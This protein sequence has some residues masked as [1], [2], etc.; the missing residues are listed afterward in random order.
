M[1]EKKTKSAEK[2]AAKNKDKNAAKNKAA[3]NTKKKSLRKDKYAKYV[4]PK[5]TLIEHRKRMGWSDEEIAKA[6]GIAYSTFKVYKN[7]YGELSA[8][9]RVGAQEADAVVESAFFSRCVGSKVLLKKPFKVVRTKEEIDG[10]M[11]DV[12]K[13]IYADEEVYFPPDV[14]A[15]K[16]YLEHRMP[17]RW[18][19]G[20]E[21]DDDNG[22]SGVVMMPEM[23]GDK[24]G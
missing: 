9:L 17:E 19:K 14:A 23:R 6:L 21:N 15:G 8:A 10:V 3:K 1:A 11:R 18:G 24:N 12:D 5:L 20:K 16:F 4:L 13:I 7:K 22:N 2:S